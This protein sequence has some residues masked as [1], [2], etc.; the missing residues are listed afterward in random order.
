MTVAL[1]PFDELWDG[2]FEIGRDLQTGSYH[3][4]P[5]TTAELACRNWF[6]AQA[7]GRGMRVETDGNGNM[8]AW[9]GSGETDGAVVSGSHLDSVPDGGAYDGA[10]GVVCAFAAIDQLRGSGFSP[11]RALAVVAFSDEEGARFG[12]A[13]VGS[14]LLTGAL[15]PEQAR[16]LRDVDGMTLEQG[17]R[18][19][20]LE[21]E[22]IGPDRAR[23]ACI[24]AFVEVHIEQGRHLVHE[25]APIGVASGIWPHGRFRFDLEGEANHAGTTPLEDRHDPILR[26]ARAALAAR[27]SAATRG[28]FATFGRLH[29]EPN[30][31]N[32]IPSLVRAWLDAR[33][34]DEA[35]VQGIVEDVSAVADADAT[36]ESWIP[37]IE[38]D[39]RLHDHLV[40]ML[41]APSLTTGAGHDAAVLAAAGVPAAML[42]VRNRTG[43]SH[44]PDE[45]V[46]RADCLTAVD[47]LTS[48]LADLAN[49]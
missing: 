24:R 15:A 17:M 37:A 6:K 12:T 18:Q 41:D 34:P 4:L 10:L 31:T 29:V 21:P 28:G 36:T 1:S 40:R 27:E 49:E 32:T 11:R 33:G 45:V 38:F 26:F 39:R 20:D 8:W 19:A 7:V 22:R 13:C 47:A 5:W 35:S 44:A 43:I 23:L 30:S 9:W 2:L 16:S 42:F 46:D 14:R 48:V 3:R 25:N